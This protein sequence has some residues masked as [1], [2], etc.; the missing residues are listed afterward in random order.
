MM[1]VVKMISKKNDVH[2]AAAGLSYMAG[3][4]SEPPASH[5]EDQT[6]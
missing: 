5:K 6:P 3:M 1:M 4:A 2:H